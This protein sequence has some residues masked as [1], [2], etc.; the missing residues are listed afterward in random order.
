MPEEPQNP[1]QSPTSGQ[2]PS[3]KANR[4]HMASPLLSLPSLFISLCI[5]A[6][7]RAQPVSTFYDQ[8]GM[9]IALVLVLI[10]LA[11]WLLFGVPAIAVG[12]VSLACLRRDRQTTASVLAPLVGIL[13]G[14]IGGLLVLAVFFGA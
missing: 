7:S 11:G 3:G 10:A 5:I 12:I 8:G 1:F 2:A 13:L 6:W 4:W 9:L 14:G